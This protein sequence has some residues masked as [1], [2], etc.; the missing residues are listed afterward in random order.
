MSLSL[1]ARRQAGGHPMRTL[2]TVGAATVAIFLFC[3]LRSIVT[4]LDAAVEASASNRIITGSAVSLFQSLPSAYMGQIEAIEGVES[5]SRFTWF[6]GRYQSEENFFAQFGCDPETLM[7]QYPELLLPDAQKRAWVRDRRGAIIGQG[8]ADQYGW[9]IG[10]TIP[11]IGTIYPRVDGSD[12]EFTVCGIYRSAKPNLDEVTMYFHWEYMDRV[13]EEGG[14]YGPRGTSVFVVKLADGF[15]GEEVSTAI[16]AYYS[17]GPQ[18]TRTQTEAAFQA[19]FVSMLGNLPTFLGMLGTAVLIAIL[20]GVVNT[21]TIAARERVRSMG[22]LKS[23]GFPNRI[24]VRLY[25]MES[26]GIVLLGGGLGML[27]A[28]LTQDPLR[29]AFGTYIPVYHVTQDTYVMAALICIAIG[30]AAGAWPAWRASRL[31]AAESIRRGV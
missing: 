24:P 25:L 12:W 30:F 26:T 15:T 2:L 8:L 22:I 4:S 19:G 11:L 7:Q 10:D 5:V 9:K 31:R 14:S 13:L 1:L 6:G 29:A 3:F 20:F 21:M 27:L 28:N 17:G 23:L 18:R 16:D